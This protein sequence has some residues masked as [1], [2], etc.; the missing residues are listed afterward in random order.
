MTLARRAPRRQRQLHQ[1]NSTL[2]SGLYKKALREG[3]PGPWLFS[4]NGSRAFLHPGKTLH[5]LLFQDN[6]S[7]HLPHVFH[8]P[9]S[10]PKTSCTLWF[11][12][13]TIL[14]YMHLFPSSEKQVSEKLRVP[15]PKSH[16]QEVGLLVF[17]YSKKPG[18]LITEIWVPLWLSKWFWYFE[19]YELW[20]T[21]VFCS[22]SMTQLLHLKK[23]NNTSYP[24]CRSKQGSAW[25]GQILW[26]HKLSLSRTNH[27][28]VLNF[29][30]QVGYED[31][32]VKVD[33]L[34]HTGF[35]VY[36]W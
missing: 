5:L 30:K 29:S 10:L 28:L 14:Q 21:Y 17:W 20:I 33:K 36:T 4:R 1:P 12:L 35:I 18:M 25:A 27:T 6:S 16:S 32:E 19:N 34:P 31:D 7:R 15:P 3:S 2:L 13:I 11:I 9:G 26:Y 22:R 8:K 23:N 24:N